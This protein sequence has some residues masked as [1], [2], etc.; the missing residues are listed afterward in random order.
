MSKEIIENN[1]DIIPQFMNWEIKEVVRNYNTYKVP[2][3]FLS[4]HIMHRYCNVLYA[5]NMEFDNSWDWLFPVL[6]K[7]RSCGCIIE[8]S[9]CF[10]TECRICIVGTKQEKTINIYS[11][12]N[13]IKG[14][15][16]CVIQFIKHYNEK[17]V[18]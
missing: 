2:S 4:G 5:H 11:E 9:M 16:D 3:D 7:I 12:L 18:K 13:G 1:N 10:Q 17:M 6:E 14:I 8:I 15:Y